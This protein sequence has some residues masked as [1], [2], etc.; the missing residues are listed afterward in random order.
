MAM[1]RNPAFAADKTYTDTAQRVANLLWE[2]TGG[3]PSKFP[4]SYLETLNHE[5][6]DGSVSLLPLLGK[7]EMEPGST[8]EEFSEVV[9]NLM[10]V[11]AKQWPDPEYI[12]SIPSGK[13]LYEIEPELVEFSEGE[14]EFD[15][16]DAG[17]MSDKMVKF[18]KKVISSVYTDGVSDVTDSEGNPPNAQNRYLMAADGKSFSGIFYDKDPERGTKQFPFVI[19]E[20]GSGQWEIK[21]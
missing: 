9:A 10:K 12:E 8:H 7:V 1:D 5:Y 20:K 14:L 18:L 21:Y 4:E 2:T 6:S 11:D 3:N 15:F 19:R 17:S 13:L 16:A